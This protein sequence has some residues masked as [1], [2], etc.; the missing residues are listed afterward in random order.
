MNL[1]PVFIFEGIVYFLI[2]LVLII[3]G[4]IAIF[5]PGRIVPAIIFLGISIIIIIYAKN[6]IK[7]AQLYQL[8]PTTDNAALPKNMKIKD[9]KPPLSA[10][11][12]RGWK[13]YYPKQWNKITC[14]SDSI[15]SILLLLFGIWNILYMKTNGNDVASA[16]IGVAAIAFVFSMTSAIG[17]LKEYERSKWYKDNYYK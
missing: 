4:G 9:E 14:I 15:L 5:I 13:Y 1:R 11:F 16:S 8:K 12:F 2:A 7:I 17:A 3:I 6:R 10:F